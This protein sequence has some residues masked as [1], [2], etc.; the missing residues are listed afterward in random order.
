MKP[1]S[2]GG[3]EPQKARGK[4]RFGNKCVKQPGG[5]N[6]KDIQKEDEKK[7]KMDTT[8]EGVE[9]QGEGK[10]QAQQRESKKVQRGAKK[11]KGTISEL[12]SPEGGGEKSKANT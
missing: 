8:G 10:G 9:S 12:A 4:K 1:K 5:G 3:G 11:K 7:R 2:E 6:V